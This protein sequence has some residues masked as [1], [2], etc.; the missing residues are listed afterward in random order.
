MPLNLPAVSLQ[1][2][3]WL[4]VA[5]RIVEN[6][7][8]GAPCRSSGD[9]RRFSSF[10]EVATSS[11]GRGG[12]RR[13]TVLEVASH[14]DNVDDIHKDELTATLCTHTIGTAMCLWTD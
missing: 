6:Y 4:F 7:L 11:A 1:R 10:R 12:P 5:E 13:G 3:H 14:L 9:H 2:S 8:N